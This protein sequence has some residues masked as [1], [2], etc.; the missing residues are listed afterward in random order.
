MSSRLPEYIAAED[1]TV[2]GLS[3]QLLSRAFPFHLVLDRSLSIVQYGV[4][5]EE[6]MGDLEP[7]RPLEAFFRIERPRIP[8]RFEVIRSLSSNAL[9]IE[10]IATTL[11]LR[12]Q[13]LISED[14][15]LLFLL[16]SPNLK[17]LS[18]FEQY[19][20]KLNHFAPHDATPDYLLALKPKEMLIDEKNRLA[21]QLRQQRRELL[22][23]KSTLEEKVEERTRDL[24]FA[25]DAAEA[26]N[27]A[28]S[29]FLAMMSHEIRTP[30]NGI[31]GVASLLLDTQLTHEQQDLLQMMQAC[32]ESLLTIINDVLDFSKI[33]AGQLELE[34][35]DFNLADC[36]EDAL[37]ILSFNAYE[38]D[39]ELGY[40]LDGAIP[41]VIIGDQTR[42][43]QI[44]INLLSNAIK[45]TEQGSVTL[46]VSTRV[47]SFEKTELAFAVTD[48]GIGIAPDRLEKLFQPFTQADTSITRR[49]GGT[50]LGLVIS[51]R[52][53]QLMNGSIS[54]ESEVGIGSTF[55]F[56][57]QMTG[58]FIPST[59]T[60]IRFEGAKAVIL[61]P[62]ETATSLPARL[63]APWGIDTAVCANLDE[64]K[65][66]YD[67]GNSFDFCFIEKSFFQLETWPETLG[68][69][70][71]LEEA[72]PLVELVPRNLSSDESHDG[73][74][75]RLNKPLQYNKV[76]DCLLQILPVHSTVRVRFSHLFPV[77]VAVALAKRI[78]NKLLL[79]FLKDLGYEAI[80]IEHFGEFED[81]T[82]RGAVDVFF[83]DE[84]FMRDAQRPAG[85]GHIVLLK[86]SQAVGNETASAEFTGSLTL[87]LR[88]DDLVDC[89]TKIH[90]MSKSL[91]T[92]QQPDPTCLNPCSI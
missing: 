88:K 44:L 55:R 27:R 49:F 66:A 38:K 69:L 19:G 12:V 5:L 53:V 59:H 13:P 33:E 21:E 80:C 37:D 68:Y 64:L 43:R 85:N 34:K 71:R 45:F 11:T 60:L 65:K 42:L 50:G 23:A 7:E 41:A 72:P 22:L 3:P 76:L 26:G 73:I 92:S 8:F 4:A 62:E 31:I 18:D 51:Q 86:D 67:N 48:T 15:S 25:K 57:I 46:S 78:N 6:L 24:Q 29:E 75:L 20:L 40:F 16:G 54:A 61:T 84:R 87:P 74:E 89:L 39:L 58:Q 70:G 36:I 90:S 14:Q 63:L 17:S 77:R 79:R 56:T 32:G 82:R 10:H 9:I 1:I 2:H 52:L 28:K 35:R 81:L 83:V 91:P 30:M 47:L